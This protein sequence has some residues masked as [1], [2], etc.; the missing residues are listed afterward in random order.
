[1]GA[2]GMGLRLRGAQM[3]VAQPSFDAL[4]ERAKLSGV[5]LLQTIDDEGARC[6]TVIQAGWMRDLPTLEAVAQWLERVGGRR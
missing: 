6:Y 1:M 4:R 3:E 2:R 5:T